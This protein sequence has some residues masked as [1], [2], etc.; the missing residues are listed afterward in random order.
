MTTHRPG[1]A[2]AAMLALAGLLPALAAAAPSAADR[3]IAEAETHV[4]RA[5]TP[6]ALVALASG[7]MRKARE[8][9]DPDYYG[10]ADAALERALAIDPRH[11]GALRARAWVRL[12]R[13]EFA[14]ALRTARTARA[15]EPRDWWNYGNL[16]DACMELGR[17]DDAARA[18]ERMMRLRPGL[19]AY[20]RVAAL[21]AIAGDRRGAIAA[22]E[23]ALAALDPADPEERAWIL[24]YLGHEHWALGDLA[25]ARAR[26]EE[27]L[28][29]FADY[30]LAIPALAHVRAAEGDVAGA[31]ALYERALVLAPTLAVA[32]A[33][34]D[35]YAAAG[36]PARAR[37][38]YEFAMAMGRVATARGRTL[39]RELAVFLV[40]H[41]GDPAAALALARSDVVRRHDVYTDDALAWVLLAN[42]LPAAAKRTSARA[43]RLGTEDASFEFHAGMIAARLGRS[44]AAARHLARALALNPHFDLVQAPRARAALAAPGA[45]ARSGS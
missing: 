14:A 1:R 4:A 24:T 8:S 31:T 40:D 35:L 5:P 9:G 2:S 41:D 36:N 21:R 37:S 19:P 12:G 26:Y 3:A 23:L 32:G 27:A 43:L 6:D 30:H 17:Y 18:T 33:L 20:T 42:G 16:A 13:H 7:F 39:G 34:G 10:R 38:T 25:A 44:R 15:V 11:Y 22:L 29:A 28:R 45:L